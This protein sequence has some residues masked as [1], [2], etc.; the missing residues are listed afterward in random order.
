MGTFRTDFILEG[1]GIAPWGALG[2]GHFKSDAQ[3]KEQEGRKLGEA[4]PEAIKISKVLEKIANEKK[5]QITSI[6]LA[7]VMHKTP[8]VFPIIGG[9]KIEH[10]K[11]NI[12]GLK[13]DLTEEDI[14]E[15]EEATP[16]DIGFP[17]NFLGGPGGVK[18]PYD[19]WLMKSAGIQQHV[20]PSRV[21]LER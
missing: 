14:K 11:G 9:R 17:N 3:R 15:I 10:L 19:V 16:F 21:S 2:G 12:D 8:Y 5:V 6:A 1:M 18:T 13:I 7:Y 4:G 20:L